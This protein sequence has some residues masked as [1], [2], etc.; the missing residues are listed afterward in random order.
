MSGYVKAHGR[1]IL[2]TPPLHQQTLRIMKKQLIIIGVGDMYALA[3]GE[4]THMV[5]I[6]IKGKVRVS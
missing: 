4:G 2:H 3:D 1:A 6:W 5:F